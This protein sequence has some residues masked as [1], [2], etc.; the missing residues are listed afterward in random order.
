MIDQF[1]PQLRVGGEPVV[2]AQSGEVQEFDAGD[3]RFWPLKLRIAI[4]QTS[5]GEVHRK[6]D[7]IEVWTEIFEVDD[8]L[9]FVNTSV[10]AW[11]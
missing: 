6:R 2:I 8:A 10:A 11:P 1:V 3:I 5:L 9:F 4:P 7:L